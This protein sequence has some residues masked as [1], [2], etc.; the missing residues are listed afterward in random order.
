MRDETPEVRPCSRQM[1]NGG[2]AFRR[3]GLL[4]VFTMRVL[5][6]VAGSASVNKTCLQRWRLTCS[7]GARR[8]QTAS[9]AEL[10]ATEEGVPG[11]SSWSHARQTERWY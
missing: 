11:S 3:G 9:A 5:R 4:A 10:H 7:L 1:R 8:Q 2:D 6:R